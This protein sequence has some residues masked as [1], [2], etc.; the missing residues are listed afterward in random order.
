MIGKSAYDFFRIAFIRDV[1]H[2]HES[3][4]PSRQT[5]AHLLVRAVPRAPIDPW[6][7]GTHRVVEVAG[8]QRSAE[9]DGSAGDRLDT[10]DQPLYARMVPLHFHG[11]ATLEY[12]QRFD[13]ERWR[14]GAY[15]L[16]DGVDLVKQVLGGQRGAEPQIDDAMKRSYCARSR[17]TV[18]AEKVTSAVLR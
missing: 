5:V 16:G 8:S 6:D 11:L 18:A 13:R 9:S 14:L 10:C 17:S 12:V 15:A 2:P 7:P 4:R 3:R 1:D